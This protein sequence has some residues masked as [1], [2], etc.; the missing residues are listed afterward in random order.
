M[1]IFQRIPHDADREEHPLNGRSEPANDIVR[2]DCIHNRGY[3]GSDEI[4]YVE[5][6]DIQIRACHTS[7]EVISLKD[8]VDKEVFP[9]VVITLKRDHCRLGSDCRSSVDATNSAGVRA[10]REGE[11]EV[12]CANVNASTRKQRTFVHHDQRPSSVCRIRKTIPA[13]RVVPNPT[14]IVDTG[15]RD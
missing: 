10:R 13:S 14:H 12:I 4:Q 6:P 2:F 15:A 3:A 8:V 7:E 11:F 9:L 1:V 5:R